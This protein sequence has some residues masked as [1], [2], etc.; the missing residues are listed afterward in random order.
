LTTETL[1][2]LILLSKRKSMNRIPFVACVFKECNQTALG[3]CSSLLR[4]FLI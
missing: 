4:L 3:K 1:K 2:V